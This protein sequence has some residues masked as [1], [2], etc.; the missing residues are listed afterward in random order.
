MNDS[1]VT[2][3][4]IL[5]YGVITALFGSVLYVVIVKLKG[6]PLLILA[7]FQLL[8]YVVYR[9]KLLFGWKF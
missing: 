4:E 9:F 6:I 7:S 5:L 8:G 3:L 1:K 2:F